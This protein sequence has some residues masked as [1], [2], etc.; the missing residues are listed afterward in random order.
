MGMSYSGVMVWCGLSSVCPAGLCIHQP[1]GFLSLYFQVSVITLGPTMRLQAYFPQHPTFHLLQN[2][3]EQLGEM[4]MGANP[5]PAGFVN[6]PAPSGI[7]Q[8]QFA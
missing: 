2:P 3:L 1:W 7:W 6:N 5:C 8:T 4:P